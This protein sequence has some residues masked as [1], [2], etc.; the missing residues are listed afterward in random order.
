M[1]SG[2]MFSSYLG[3]HSFAF[4]EIDIYIIDIKVFCSFSSL[5]KEEV[6]LV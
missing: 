6:V 1:S 2:N 4:L 3:C 5:S